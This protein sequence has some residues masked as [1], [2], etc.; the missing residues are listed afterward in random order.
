M[1]GHEHIWTLKRVG[2]ASGRPALGSVTSAVWY[3]C[4]CGARRRTV[5]VSK[6]L[7]QTVEY[8]DR[9]RAGDR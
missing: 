9:G 7:R 1:T 3:V 5:R 6:L 4:A 8:R 2:R